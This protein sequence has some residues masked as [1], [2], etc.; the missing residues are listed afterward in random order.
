MVMMN[1]KRSSM[2]VLNALYMKARH[3]RCATDL[4]CR[5]F[6]PVIY[7]FY[8]Q[9]EQILY[10]FIHNSTAKNINLLTL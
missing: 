10:T 9:V 2:K 5:E 1:A 7:H 4:S 3:G 6:A 8:T